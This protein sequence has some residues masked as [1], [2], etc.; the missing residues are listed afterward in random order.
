MASTVFS[1]IRW[2]FR[3]LTAWRLSGCPAGDRNLCLRL[4]IQC[5]GEDG[6]THEPVEQWYSCHANGRFFCPADARKR[7]QLGTLRQVRKQQLPLPWLHKLDCRWN[8][9]R[10]KVPVLSK[11]KCRLDN[12]WLRQVQI[13]ICCLSCQ[14]IMNMKNRICHRQ[15]SLIN[16]MAYKEEI[17]PRI[18]SCCSR[19]GKIQNHKY[20]SRWCRSRYWCLRSLK[21]P[22]PKALSRIWLHRRKSQSSS[23]TWNNSS[24]QWVLVFLLESKV[25]IL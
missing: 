14:R 5:V 15:M 9:W 12:L 22:A 7:K 20:W 19:N 11:W 16:K 24:N 23:K 25:L 1:C 6:P 10:H 8:N 18:T 2:N 3:L 13:I 17:L 21:A 4:M